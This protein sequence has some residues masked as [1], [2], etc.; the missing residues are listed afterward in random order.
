MIYNVA[1]GIEVDFRLLGMVGEKNVSATRSQHR[2][3]LCIQFSIDSGT[4]I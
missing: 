4:V 2:C 3:D 1:Q